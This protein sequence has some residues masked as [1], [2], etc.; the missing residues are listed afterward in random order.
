MLEVCKVTNPDISTSKRLRDIVENYEK[1]K[2]KELYQ[3]ILFDDGIAPS[4]FA[5]DHLVVSREKNN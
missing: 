2:T 3:A 1:Y 4:I 5:K